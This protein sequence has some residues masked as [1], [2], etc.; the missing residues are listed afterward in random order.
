MKNMIKGVTSCV[1]KAT[2]I[3]LLGSLMLVAAGPGDWQVGVVD[4]GIGGQYSSL[5]VD[6][7]GNGHVAYVDSNDAILKYAFWDHRLNKWFTTQLDR[8]LGFCSLAL[9]SGQRPHISYLDYGSGRLKYAHWNGATWQSQTIQIQAKQISFYTSIALG[10]ND[11]PSITYY[12]YE[13]PDGEQELHLRNVSWTGDRWELRTV[14]P[15]PGSG[16]FNSIASDSGG[17]LHVA[18]GN[19]KYE[20][21]SL[22]YASFDG[23]SW[24]RKILEGEGRP[25]TS[26]WSTT[27]VMDKADQPH[28][29]YTDV[30]NKIVKYATEINGRWVFEAVDSLRGVGYPDR[31]GIALDEAGTPY[32]SYYDAG[33]G[34]LKLAH[35]VGRQWVAEVVDGNFAGYTNSLQIYQQTIWITYADENQHDLK[36]ARRTISALPPTAQASKENPNNLPKR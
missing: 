27:L 4:A 1:A 9:D 21:A 2:G 32:I 8:S 28:I 24:N 6:A 19:V 25:G 13:G 36:F 35:R 5:R 14:D 22:R 17:N 29:A 34:L 26:M 18:Y 23:H 30:V 20:D 11:T 10:K 12:E 3:V 7:Y 33:A 16:K 15:T 31:N